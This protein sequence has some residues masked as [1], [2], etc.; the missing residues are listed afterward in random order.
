MTLRLQQWMA[1]YMRRRGW[2]VF[3]L[4]PSARE[5]RQGWCWMQEYQAQQNRERLSR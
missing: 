2:A 1:R 3:Y 4:D 5:C